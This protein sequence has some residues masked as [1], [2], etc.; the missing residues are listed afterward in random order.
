[1]VAEV[2]GKMQ[3]VSELAGGLKQAEVAEAAETQA[4]ARQTLELLSQVSQ[5]F[6]ATD[7]SR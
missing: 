1:M 7:G 5:Y 6:D 3:D 4:D 2:S